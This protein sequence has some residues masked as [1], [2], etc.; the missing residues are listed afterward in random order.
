MKELPKAIA[1]ALADN[2]EQVRVRATEGEEVN[3]LELPVH[4][5]GQRQEPTRAYESFEGRIR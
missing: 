5:R 1:K 2:A 3:V 4:S